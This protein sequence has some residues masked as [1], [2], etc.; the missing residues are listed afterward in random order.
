MADL[1]CAIEGQQKKCVWLVIPM[2]EAVERAAQTGGAA[3]RFSPSGETMHKLFG[4]VVVVGLLLVGCGNDDDKK[5][6]AV[7]GS[8]TEQK[9]CGSLQTGRAAGE[10]CNGAIECAEVCCNCSSAGK[11]YT[12]KACVE[13]KC[14]TASDA[15]ERVLKLSPVYC[16]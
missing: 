11:S 6:T 2:V 8:Q 5:T 15:C 14:A 1:L 10:E 13:G 3:G 16:E 4:G 7:S 12:A 9:T